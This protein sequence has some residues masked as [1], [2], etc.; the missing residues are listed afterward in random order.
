M[1]LGQVTSSLQATLSLPLLHHE[2]SFAYLVYL[3]CKPFGIGTFSL[4]VCT[5]PTTMR[6]QSQLEP[7]G[8]T[9]IQIS[10][11]YHTV[12]PPH[13]PSIRVDIILM[14]QQEH[15]FR[16]WSSS[17]QV[18]FL[19]WIHMHLA[20]W[21]MGLKM[22]TGLHSQKKKKIGTWHKKLRVQKQSHRLI[23]LQKST[24]N[25]HHNAEIP[26]HLTMKV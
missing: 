4:Y 3:E 10:N 19:Y 12:I 22:T 6:P 7:L 17:T 23:R 8:I 13:S 2:C 14:N 16:R 9:V 26:L 24:L 25:S 20:R 15:S 5:V 18:C 11:N 1:S 21:V